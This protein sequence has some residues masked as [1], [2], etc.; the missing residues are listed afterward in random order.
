V[1]GSTSR[2]LPGPVRERQLM[3][4]AEE[5]FTTHGYADTTIEDIARAAGVTR[6]IVYQHHGSKQG[7]FLACVQRARQ[8]FQ[9]ALREVVAAPDLS[10]EG[11]LE[12]GSDRFFS[13]L[14][15]NPRRWVVL[16]ASSTAMSGEL[17]DR[18]TELRFET[19]GLIA[20]L[21]RRWAPDVDDERLH[22]TAHAI[23]GAGEQLGRWWLKNPGIPRTKVVHH[24]TELMVPMARSGLAMA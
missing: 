17:S 3:D 20:N 11:F 15:R 22:A 21:L 16:F 23:S 5:L 4:L 24:F 14:E 19:V 7:L 6:P 1:V 2:R 10:L 13:I 12:R 9:E 18:L 8:E